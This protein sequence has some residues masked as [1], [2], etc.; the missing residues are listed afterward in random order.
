MS[1]LQGRLLL[2]FLHALSSWCVSSG[3]FVVTQSPDVSVMEGKTVSI[4]CCWTGKFERFRVYWLKNQTE[5]RSDYFNQPNASLKKEEKKCSSLNISNVRTVD[6]G[7][8]IC[9]V[10]VEIPSLAEAKGNG[11]VITVKKMGTSG[12]FVTVKAK[13]KKDKRNREEVKKVKND[14]NTDQH[15][16]QEAPKEEVFTYLMRT[17]PVLA[18]ITAFFWLY[19]VGSKAQQ[20]SKAS[21]GNKPTSSQK[22]EQ[23]EE[24]E[25]RDGRAVEAAN[26]C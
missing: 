14:D 8:Y 5:I 4:T 6:S 16:A 20:N 13:K 1:L 7:T 21:S 22:Q 18:L 24:E 26:E 2:L 11:T 17:L 15:I 12:T 10:T 25:E 23:D 9:K 3:T 19:Y